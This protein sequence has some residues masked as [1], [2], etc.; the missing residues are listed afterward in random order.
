M[1][2]FPSEGITLYVYNTVTLY[3]AIL[4]LHF[5]A[6]IHMHRDIHIVM[7]MGDYRW[8]LDW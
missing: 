8:G 1:F 6:D 5:E 2:G 3:A 4:C 7:C